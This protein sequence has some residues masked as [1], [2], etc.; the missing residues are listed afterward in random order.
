MPFGARK[1]LSRGMPCRESI[2]D[3]R[4]TPGIL[5]G[6]LPNKSPWAFLKMKPLSR[7]ERSAEHGGHFKPAGTSPGVSGNV[8]RMRL[9]SGLSVSYL[10]DEL[11][12]GGVAPGIGT[13]A[14][15]PSPPAARFFPFALAGVGFACRTAAAG[16][17]K[18]RAPCMCGG[19]DGSVQP[20]TSLS[21]PRGTY[22][23]RFLIRA[24]QSNQR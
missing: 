14:C 21:P 7:E 23:A 4:T 2:I 3:E 12:T 9:L 5:L 17:Q 1:D 22:L 20:G 19:P 15:L 16:I 13:P 18:F 10:P 24:A 8:V 11:E 6:T